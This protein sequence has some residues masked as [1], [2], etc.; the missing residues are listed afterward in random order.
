MQRDEIGLVLVRLAQ[1]GEEEVVGRE[2]D[3][4]GGFT[5]F[6]GLDSIG[7]ELGL[8]RAAKEYMFKGVSFR[9][10]AGGAVR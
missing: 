4:G 1:W 9:G 10:L 2:F 5:V 8:G 3:R 7:D 6:E